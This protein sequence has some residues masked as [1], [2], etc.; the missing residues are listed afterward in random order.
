MCLELLVK[1]LVLLESDYFISFDKL[2]ITNLCY[3]L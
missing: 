2:H 1:Y 3:G